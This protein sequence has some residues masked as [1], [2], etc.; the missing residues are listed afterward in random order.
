MK[1]YVGKEVHRHLFFTSVFLREGGG[2]VVLLNGQLI[3]GKE[4]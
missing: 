3:V 2:E 4:K 1:A